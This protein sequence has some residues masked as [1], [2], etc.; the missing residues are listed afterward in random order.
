MH[1]TGGA[2]NARRTRAFLGWALACAPPL[3]FVGVLVAS[4]F[5]GSPIPMVRETVEIRK[6]CAWVW[7]YL[8]DSSH[9][10]EWSIF[11]N[12]ITPLNT[13]QVADGGAGSI[14]R[15]FQNADET[16]LRWDEHFEEV[17]SSRRRLRIFNVVDTPL[18]TTALLLTDQIYEPIGRDHCRL[19]FT[20]FFGGKP[21]LGDAIKIRLAGH[22]V[23]RTFRANLSNIKRLIEAS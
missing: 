10:S 8:G 2:G 7:D 22:V 15:S 23:N 16:G 11:V 17:T 19:S 9:A 20:L 21:S 1:G 6:A 18:P 5:R 3:V 13:P 14:R 12:H 4:P